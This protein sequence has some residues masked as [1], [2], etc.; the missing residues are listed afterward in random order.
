MQFGINKHKYIFSKTAKLHEPVRRV[1]FMVFEK[2]YK[3]LFTP[4]CMRKIPEKI[5]DSLIMII[6]Q[7][8]SARI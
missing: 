6:M 5:Q 7:E 1:P 4:N 2:I 3:C 8:Q